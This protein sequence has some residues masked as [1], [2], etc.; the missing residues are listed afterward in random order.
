MR[1]GGFLELSLLFGAVHIEHTSLRGLMLLPTSE[2]C[3]GGEAATTRRGLSLSSDDVDDKADGERKW[4]CTA[5][6]EAVGFS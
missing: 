3:D 5:I 6:R 4:N 2:G 1:R